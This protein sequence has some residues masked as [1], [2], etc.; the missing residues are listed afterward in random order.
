[1]FW[2]ISNQI[3]FFFLSKN[4]E[5]R[6]KENRR[7]YWANTWCRLEGNERE[8]GML[9]FRIFATTLILCKQNCQLIVHY[10]RVSSC[11]SPTSLRLFLNYPLPKL[12]QIE[13]H[14]NTYINVMVTISVAPYCNWRG[15]C[16]DWLGHQIF[17]Q[18]GIVSYLAVQVQ[19]LS[20]NFFLPNGIQF[21]T[22]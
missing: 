17:W 12:F 14:I 13:R 15:V 22:H 21:I 6:S 1:M 8:T 19:L 9:S 10:F 3:G 11:F 7:H 5:G 18:I 4:D 16:V 2:K 20:H